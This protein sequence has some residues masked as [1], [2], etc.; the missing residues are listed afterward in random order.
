MTFPELFLVYGAVTIMTTR[1]RAVTLLHKKSR[2]RVYVQS[3]PS[4]KH[5]LR[6]WLKEATEA[7][8]LQVTN[9]V[10]GIGGNGRPSLVEIRLSHPKR[11]LSLTDCPVPHFHA[12]LDW[13]GGN[14]PP[15]I[16]DS[17]RLR[18]G[19]SLELLELKVRN[20]LHDIDQVAKT[21]SIKVQVID[22][23]S[24][25]NQVFPDED[26]ERALKSDEQPYEVPW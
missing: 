15:C 5:L 2:Y 21:H 25:R 19:G 26:I 12:D 24:K 10:Y 4:E 6:L 9:V 8:N 17:V 18:Y 23:S 3:V 13:P 16:G 22:A 14:C 20:V 11:K 7:L 1:L